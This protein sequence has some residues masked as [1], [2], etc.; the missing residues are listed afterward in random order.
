MTAKGAEDKQ[1]PEDAFASAAE[2]AA[3]KQ[4][5]AALEATIRVMA[6]RAIRWLFE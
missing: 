6:E 3:L 4:R 5:I 2:V 1:S